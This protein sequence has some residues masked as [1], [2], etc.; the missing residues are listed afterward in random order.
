[1]DLQ[2]T[3]P[4]CGPVETRHAKRAA[5]SVHVIGRPLGRGTP[6]FELKEAVAGEPDL[7]IVKRTS[8]RR[9]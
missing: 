6:G 1:V 5:A 8:S 2:G 4:P 7:P 9:S 3:V